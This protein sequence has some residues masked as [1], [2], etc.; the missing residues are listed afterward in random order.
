MNH[1][2]ER[3]EFLLSRK[4]RGA[5]LLQALTTTHHITTVYQKNGKLLGLSNVSMERISL[6]RKLDLRTND[7][8]FLLVCGCYTDDMLN[9]NRQQILLKNFSEVFSTPT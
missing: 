8:K 3:G 2:R 4:N 7:L 5:S 6:C 1:P 9:S